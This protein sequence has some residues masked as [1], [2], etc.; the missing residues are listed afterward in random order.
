MSVSTKLCR[1]LLT[2][3]CFSYSTSRLMSNTMTYNCKALNVTKAAPYV[4]SVELNR[5][6]KMNAINKAMWEEVG[7]VFSKLDRDQECRVVILSAAGKMFS[8]GIDRLG[9]CGQVEHDHAAV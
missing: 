6:N 1:H 4:F 3:T 2:P 9:G 7:E 8:S 5:P